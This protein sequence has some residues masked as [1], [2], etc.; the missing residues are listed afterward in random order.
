MFSWF[1]KSRSA[2]PGPDYSHVDSKAKAQALVSKGELAE[3]YLL[4]A[5]FGG[6][7]NPHNVVYVPAFVLDVKYGID[8]NTIQPLAEQGKV[9]RYVATPKYQGRSV[10][11]S[12]IEIQASEPASFQAVVRIWGE[13][14][15]EQS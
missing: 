13:A 4:P 7:D 14:I 12:A 6:T 8:S 2:P 9:K 11:P 5:I 3:M 1:K 10:V 15:R